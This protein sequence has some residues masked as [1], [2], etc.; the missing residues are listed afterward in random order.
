MKPAPVQDDARVTVGRWRGVYQIPA[1]CPDPRDLQ[2]RAD[3]IVAAHLSRECAVC[4]GQVLGSGDAS[5]WRIKDLAVNFSLETGLP[6]AVAVARK[7]GQQL[8]T[9]IFSTV[10][11]G[12]QSDSVLR[13][14]N[15]VAYL[16]RF[17]LDLVAGRA[18]GKWHYEEFEELYILSDRQ[19]IRAVFL[20]CDPSAVDLLSEILAQGGLESV[21]NALTEDD[22]RA[23]FAACFADVADV[24]S[25]EGLEK[26]TGIVLEQWVSAPLRAA[27]RHENRHRDALRLLARILS[28]FPAACTDIPLKC[29]ID[30]LLGLRDILSLGY[31]PHWIDS[32]LNSLARCD[33]DQ[34]LALAIEAGAYDPCT[35]LAFFA[36]RMKGDADWGGQAAAVLLGESH[37][38]KFLTSKTISEGESLLSS[39]AGVFL[40]AGSL[41]DLNFAEC[42]DSAA[43]SAENPA[44]VSALLRHFTALKCLGSSRFQDAAD[45]PGV[46]LFSG[47][48]GPSFRESI[49]KLDAQLLEFESLQGSFLQS[50]KNRYELVPPLLFAERIS[51]LEGIPALLVRDLMRDEWLDFVPVAA[52]GSDAKERAEESLKR[53]FAAWNQ[54]EIPALLS[55][56]IFELVQSP[57]LKRTAAKLSVLPRKND[58]DCARLASRLGL[59]LD[60]LADRIAAGEGQA[61]YY[62]LLRISPGFALH[63]GLDCTFTL[64]A[65]AAMKSFARKLFGFAASSPEHLYRN[66]LAGLGEIRRREG[67][68]EVRLPASPLSLILRMARLQEQRISPSWHKG[69]QVWLL[70]P[71][72]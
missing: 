29:V 64:I 11:G 46:R 43:E 30:N 15:R 44:K 3:Q 8:A 71:R 17:V 49:G 20:R 72:E 70:P 45:D 33:L 51:L 2:R 59:T 67:H 61:P 1:S 52:D 57:H 34:A 56:S 18:K 58:Q 22:A 21:L 37:Q 38:Q 47:F 23:I 39:F 65:R 40:L 35:V 66:F 10:E 60:Q 14:P 41:D 25:E 31:S 28:K 63:P 16:A 9:E 62:S 13:Y 32:L 69:T 4:L 54:L 27:T 68:L 53:I 26:W 36:E 55:E 19:A 6:D 24:P 5:V 50:M 42:L 48:E 7:W 12:E